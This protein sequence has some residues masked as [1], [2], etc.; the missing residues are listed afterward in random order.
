[1]TTVQTS[2][3]TPCHPKFLIA[4]PELAEG[5][6]YAGIVI[7]EAGH[8]TH[9]LILLPQQPNARLTWN[10]AMEWAKCCGGELPTRQEQALLYANLKSAFDP[11]WHWSS[12]QYAG[13]TALAWIQIFDDGMQH[14]YV[15]G[16][17]GRV[18]V[19][20]RALID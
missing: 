9:H 11:E 18:R 15:V 20:R 8:P 7:D 17:K 19:V 14:F 1:M 4:L 12:E 13:D 6:Q 2:A 16:Y 5:E 10:A 3:L